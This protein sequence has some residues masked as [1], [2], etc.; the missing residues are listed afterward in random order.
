MTVTRV[1]ILYIYIMISGVPIK[2]MVVLEAAQVDQG[3]F[4]LTL[5]PPYIHTAVTVP[6]AM[7]C[8]TRSIRYSDLT[9]SYVYVLFS[10]KPGRP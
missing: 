10:A 4:L 5:F 8:M 1:S 7:A 6:C 9:P 3:Y 2:C